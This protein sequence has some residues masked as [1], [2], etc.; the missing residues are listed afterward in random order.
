M[1]NIHIGE[2]IIVSLEPDY[3]LDCKIQDRVTLAR[4]IYLIACRELEKR[5][6]KHTGPGKLHWNKQEQ[7]YIIEFVRRV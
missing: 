3:I 4:E 7:K 1:N 6:I 2:R 5:N